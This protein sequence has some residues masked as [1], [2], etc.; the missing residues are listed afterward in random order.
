MVSR[1]P[2]LVY[3]VQRLDG[4]ALRLQ[5][6]PERDNAQRYGDDLICSERR[7]VERVTACIANVSMLRRADLATRYLCASSVICSSSNA[8]YDP[9]R[10]LRQELGPKAQSTCGL[11]F[12]VLRT[13]IQRQSNVPLISGD[14]TQLRL[15]TESP[16]GYPLRNA[17]HPCLHLCISA[18]CGTPGRRVERKWPII[19][20]TLKA[21]S[22]AVRPKLAKVCRIWDLGLYRNKHDGTF[23]DVG[24]LSGVALSGDGMQQGSMGVAWGDYLHQGRLSMVVTNFVEQG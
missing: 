20:A 15:L 14:H 22:P 13:I 19:R 4:L 11:F 2:P 6:T 5:F 8:G 1:A 23:E 9:S 16:S 17:R 18:S 21:R 10:L 3:P 7:E 24:L 12:I